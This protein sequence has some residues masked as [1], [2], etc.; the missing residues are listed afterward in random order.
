MRLA[1]SPGP[2][3]APCSVM[4]V[5]SGLSSQ[6]AAQLRGQR[7]GSYM[8]DLNEVFPLWSSNI[9]GLI[10]V[11][12]S[13]TDVSVMLCSAETLALCQEVIYL[14]QSARPASVGLV[15]CQCS[16]IPLN[17]GV[18]RNIILL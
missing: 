7:L 18:N 6:P 8:S 14:H 15:L 4:R 11:F 16:Y 2:F 5:S 1:L 9:L 10:V 12:Y 3:S 17:S 13:V